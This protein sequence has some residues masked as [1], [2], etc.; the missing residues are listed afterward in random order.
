M[1][2]SPHD[3]LHRF[4]Y[5]F[6]SLYQLPKQSQRYIN[7]QHALTNSDFVSQLP[8]DT[9]QIKRLEKKNKEESFGIGSGV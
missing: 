2:P 8:T 5:R 7:T 1:W 4:F 6:A 9:A 3:E